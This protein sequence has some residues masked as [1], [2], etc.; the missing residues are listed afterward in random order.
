MSE[1]V[2][3]EFAASIGGFMGASFGVRWDGQQLIYRFFEDRYELTSTEVVTPSET[4]WKRFWKTCEHVGVWTWKPKYELQVCDGT[5]WSFVAEVC[6][7]KIECGGS[8]AYPP[9]GDSSEPSQQFSKFCR[10][11]ETLLGGRKFQ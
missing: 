7:R 10:A 5:H 8:N 3:T 4:D 6:G 9:N 2:P 11:V 1:H